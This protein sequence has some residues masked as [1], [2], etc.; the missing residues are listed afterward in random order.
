MPQWQL[1]A[2]KMRFEIFA[3][4]LCLAVGGPSRGDPGPRYGCKSAGY[5]VRTMERDPALDTILEREQRRRVRRIMA[6]NA[7][8]VVTAT[9]LGAL[10][11]PG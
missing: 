10:L 1:L 4:D 2:P 8:I 11:F 6:A 3:P 5:I 9:A 7:A